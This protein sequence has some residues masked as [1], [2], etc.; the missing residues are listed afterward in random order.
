MCNVLRDAGASSIRLTTRLTA[1]GWGRGTASQ[2]R[3]TTDP[4]LDPHSGST[5]DRCRVRSR[6]APGGGGY[7]SPPVSP[8]T[9]PAA[10]PCRGVP[11]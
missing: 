1:G 5:A 11:G 10:P 4:G 7:R 8:P 3:G 2:V 9:V 6:R